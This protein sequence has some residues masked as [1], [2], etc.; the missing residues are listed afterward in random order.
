VQEIIREFARQV[1]DLIHWLVRLM[2]DEY[3][4]LRRSINRLL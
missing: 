3:Q 1:V 4:F 2:I